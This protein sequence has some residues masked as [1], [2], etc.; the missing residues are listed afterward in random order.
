MTG[1]YSEA[2]AQDDS[3]SDLPQETETESLPT[4]AQQPLDLTVSTTLA[5]PNIVTTSISAPLHY[6]E[7]TDKISCHSRQPSTSLVD[8]EK[9]SSQNHEYIVPDEQLN[10]CGIFNCRPARMQ[11][12]ARIKVFF[13]LN[14]IQYQST[15][16]TTN[17]S[18]IFLDFRFLTFHT[19]HT[20]TSL[21]FWL[22][23]F[24]Y[25]NNRETLRYS[26]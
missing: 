10:E 26:K 13:S 16:K 23:K 22:Y 21:K 14:F 5:N 1:L 2:E 12:F 19:R 9:S 24:S 7:T 3:S 25:N 11:K 4:T 20:S 8:R 17:V 18:C 6:Q 15:L